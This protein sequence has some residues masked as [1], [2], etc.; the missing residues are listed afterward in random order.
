MKLLFFLLASILF[1][2]LSP[3]VVFKLL[4]KSSKTT[5]IVVHTLIFA[6]SLIVLCK[7]IYYFFG[8]NVEEYFGIVDTVCTEAK[9][10][11]N[12]DFVNS[13]SVDASGNNIVGTD[14]DKNAMKNIIVETLQ[15]IANA[16]CDRPPRNLPSGFDATVKGIEKLRNLI[17]S[18]G[19]SITNMEP[20]IKIKENTLTFATD[21]EITPDTID[22]RILDQAY[23]RQTKSES[24]VRKQQGVGG[25][26]P[27]QGAPKAIPKAPP[28]KK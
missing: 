4:K 1:V 2:V 12:L 16:S 20:E 11:T 23:M 19:K 7:L 28:K 3:G 13:L 14:I 5:Q 8:E 21:L 18:S 22:F 27:Q 25:P 9:K 17:T 6:F 15:G 10:A 24:L 26:P